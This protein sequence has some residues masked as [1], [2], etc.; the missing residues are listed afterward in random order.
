[1][2]SPT[3]VSRSRKTAKVLALAMAMALVLS[4]C[5][6]PQQN[7]VANRINTS[8]TARNLR[9]MGQNLELTRKAQA[10]AEHLARTGRLEH[11]NLSSGISYRWRALG[12]NVGV[13]SSIRSVHTSYMRSP[14]HRANILSNKFNYVGTGHATRGGRVYT[15]QVFMQY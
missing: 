5:F 12:E 10:W 13:G 1:M 4:S 15:V 9:P 8:R 6:T 3:A 14:G 7:E 2:P 11:S